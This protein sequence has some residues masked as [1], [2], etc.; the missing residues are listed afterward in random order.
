MAWGLA[1]GVPIGEP[2]AK[3]PAQLSSLAT[4]PPRRP[5]I[6]WG[7]IA[8]LAMSLAGAWSLMEFQKIKVIYSRSYPNNELVA[9]LEQGQKSLLFA[10]YADFSVTMI[11]V[12]VVRMSE[13][14]I[15][16]GLRRAVHK[17]IDPQMMMFWA[18]RLAAQGQVD[19]ARWLAQRRRELPGAATDA[20]FEICRDSA[21]TAFQCQ[22]PVETHSW[23]EFATP[24]RAGVMIRS[25][26]AAT[27][28]TAPAAASAQPQASRT[29]R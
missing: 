2:K 10:H 29:S 20:A 8:G 11:P 4:E 17:S 9:L 1:L 21:S 5:K 18:E 24:A 27:S 15:E 16:L 28:D 25:I 22:W 7:F 19:L 3:D 26:T 6:E 12:K 13:A 14:S 23:R